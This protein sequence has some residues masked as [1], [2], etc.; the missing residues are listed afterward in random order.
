M[1]QENRDGG[2]DRMVGAVAH[3]GDVI[4]DQTVGNILARHGIP[5]VP[6][7][8]SST[9]WSEFIR[10][11]MAVLV[12]TDFLSV[13]VLTLRGVVTDSVVLFMPLA[14]RRV[15]IAGSTPHPNERWM[16][17]RARHAPRAGGGCLQDTRSLLP[18]REA[19][20]TPS[21]RA[22]VGSGPVRPLTLPARSP[23]LNA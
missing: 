11:H 19:T 21:F 18:D 13:E 5:P 22:M 14:S 20:Y 15:E 3:L 4:S 1:A 12:G 8:K 16:I 2:S 10:R 9:R 17:P 7:R 6:E 23:N